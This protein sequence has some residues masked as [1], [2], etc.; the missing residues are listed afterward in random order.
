MGII[1]IIPKETSIESQIRELFDQNKT[2]GDWINWK[3]IELLKIFLT[4]QSENNKLKALE[5][6][7]LSNY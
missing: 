7:N 3:N 4:T 2:E 1:K 5:L 6:L